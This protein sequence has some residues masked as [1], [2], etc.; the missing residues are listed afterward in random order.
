MSTPD[1]AYSHHEGGEV[2]GK[3]HHGQQVEDVHC[4]QE[5]QVD[6]EGDGGVV[7][8]HESASTTHQQAQGWVMPG[9]MEPREGI[10]EDCRVGGGEVA[11]GGP[12]QLPSDTCSSPHP[13]HGGKGGSGEGIV[14]LLP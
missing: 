13:S 6:L 3:P 5:H 1:A 2:Q 11:G 10:K 14:L 7:T 4:Q 12:S 8:Q 9:H